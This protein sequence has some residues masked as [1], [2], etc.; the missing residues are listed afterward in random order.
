MSAKLQRARSRQMVLFLLVCLIMLSLLGRLYYWQIIR[1]D[2]LARLAEEEHR[3]NLVVNAPRGLI[4]DRN[5]HLL[6][7]NV[8]RDDVYIEPYQL[9][10][11][12]PDAEKAQHKQAELIRMLRK[13][14]P[15]IPEEKLSRSF[16]S[17]LSTV[18]IAT[19]IEPEQS[20][21]L[22]QLHLQYVFL[23]PRPVRVYPNGDLA[24]QLLGYVQPDKGGLYGIE[25]AYNTMLAG[26]PGSLTAETDLNGNPLIVG[27]SSQQPAVKGAN[28]TLTIDSTMQYIVQTALAQR[29]KE[30]DA[31]G[32]S[33]IVVDVKTGAIVAMASVP[34]FDPN[35]YSDYYNKLGCL[36]S[37]SVYFNP[38]MYCT[39][40]PGSTMKAVT[41]AMA[42]DQGLIT[43]GQTFVDPGIVY[44]K[45]AAPVRNWQG[46]AY[47]KSTMT[48]ILTNSSNVGAAKIAHDLLTARLFYPYLEKFGFGQ[49]TGIGG[50][51]QAGTYRTEKS[52]GWT[53]TDLTRQSFGQAITATPLQVVMA[54]ATIANQGRMM[55][56]YL[57]ASTEMDGKIQQTQP[58]VLRTVLQEKAAKQLQEMLV[59]AADHNR[60]GT[61]PGYSVAVKSGTATTQGISDDQTVASMAGFLPASNP[62]F[63]LLVKLDHPQKTIYGGTAA[64]PL[65][66][67]IG[68]QLMWYYHIE[69]DRSVS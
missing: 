38:A 44:F 35:H 19:L 63:A 46:K 29:V 36:H 40:E 9:A 54:Y 34:S 48:D 41:L 52:V 18:R 47:G 16:A 61:I 67:E 28:I 42:L 59:S 8:I 2:D 33:A 62:Q 3:Q 65:W 23:E 43:P 58:H 60:Q 50:A 26:K 24:A 12:I 6:A 20:E 66:G 14:L 55:Q 31:Q 25:G 15:D 69:P 68:R 56:P 30:V 37:V 22:R 7:S 64:A 17:G 27:A 39:Y 49:V 1:H 45:D 53:P 5:G 4:F 13:V 11:D 57:V 51:E 32:G 21:Q 10:L